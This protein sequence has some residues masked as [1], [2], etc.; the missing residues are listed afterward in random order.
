MKNQDIRWLQRF[1]NYKKALR[2]L[3][4]SV[5]Y[6]TNHITK[7][8]LDTGEEFGLIQID[9]IKQGLIQS[10]EF[11]HELAWNVIKDYVHY[12]GNQSVRG[13]RDATREGFSM[14]LIEDGDVWMEMI[15]SRNQTSHTYDEETADEIYNKIIN[16]YFDA[17]VS[18]KEKMEEIKNEESN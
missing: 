13:S 10:F 18:F 3:E 14:G 9:L 15:R 17:F 6:V 5:D 12:Q 16:D 4:D 7:E 11:T 8:S 2:K 1:S